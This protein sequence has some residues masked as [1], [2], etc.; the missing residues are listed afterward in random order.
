MITIGVDAHKQVPVAVALDRTGQPCGQWEG[1]N[2]AE[3]WAALL[4]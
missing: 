1:E 2:S 3:G 4:A